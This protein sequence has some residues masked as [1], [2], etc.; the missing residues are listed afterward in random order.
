MHQA[1]AE[2]ID[3]YDSGRLSRRQLIGALVALGGGA[4]PLP[5]AGSPFRGVGLNHIAVRVT[6]IPR[7]KRFYQELLGLSLISESASSCFLQLG[8]EFL[9]FFKNEKPG[10]DHFCIAIENFKPEDVMS[11]L[12]ERGLKPRRPSGTDRIYF[13][14]PDGLE[15]QFSAV[16][17]R[18]S[19]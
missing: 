11:R 6:D 9:T 12:G 10:L 17:H 4:S 1:I 14:D 13:P 2:L 5:A 18:A 16:D 15:V 19:G 7:S 3:R 8:E